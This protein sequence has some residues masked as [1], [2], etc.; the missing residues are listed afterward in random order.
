[1]LTIWSYKSRL[2]TPKHFLGI[3]CWLLSKVFSAQ[4]S[5]KQKQGITCTISGTLTSFL[6]QLTLLPGLVDS[7]QRH[8]VVH[9][10][11]EAHAGPQGGDTQRAGQQLA[12][13][14]VRVGAQGDGEGSYQ[15]HKPLIQA[16]VLPSLHHTTSIRWHCSMTS[17]MYTKLLMGPKVQCNPDFTSLASV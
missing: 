5:T 17:M 13:G 7:I 4:A 1:M 15:L 6:C 3:S 8:S 12:P 11:D 9:P 10:L 2:Y 16:Q 14:G